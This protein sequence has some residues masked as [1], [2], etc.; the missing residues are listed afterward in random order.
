MKEEIHGDDQENINADDGS[1]DASEQASFIDLVNDL[2]STRPDSIPEDELDEL[3][4]TATDLLSEDP[5][6]RQI[7]ANHEGEYAV[8]NYYT[9]KF[10]SFLILGSSL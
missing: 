5:A 2:A 1:N 7:L 4:K 3:V 9:A 10:S 6:N 8:V